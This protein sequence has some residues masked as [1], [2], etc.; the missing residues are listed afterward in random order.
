MQDQHHIFHKKFVKQ[1]GEYPEWINSPLNIVEVEHFCHINEV[2]SVTGNKKGELARLRVY[3]FVMVRLHAYVEE[4]YWE[5]SEE[6]VSVVGRMYKWCLIDN[7]SKQTKDLE[8]I[9]QYKK[10]CE[11][12]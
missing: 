1:K 5:L 10:I 3:E 2:H 6:E 9:E 7:H 8:L 12:G 11:R 4:D